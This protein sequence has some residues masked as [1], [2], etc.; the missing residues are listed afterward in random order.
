MN[1][2]VNWNPDE[3][4]IG[5]V[6]VAPAATA[7]FYTKL[8]QLTPAKKDWEHVRVIVDS[9]PKIPSRGRFF[10]LGE[11][12]P[13]PYIRQSIE[14]LIQV[15]ASIIAVPCNTAHVLYERYM[16]GFTI[17]IPNM[18]SLTVERVIQQSPIKPKKA[19]VFASKTTVEH[20][21]YNKAF[22]QHGII[23]NDT[24]NHQIEISA[25]I[26]KVKQGFSIALLRKEMSHLLNSY[27]EE[28]DV[29]I[30]GCTEL[31]LLI[32]NHYQG[33]AVIDS[34]MTLAESC[35]KMANNSAYLQKDINSQVQQY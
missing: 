24:S 11:T 5:V 14:Q 12:D 34:N 20:G 25:L 22:K 23:V 32:E 28:S 29:F 35:L 10:D 7:D 1:K 4:I 27:Q 21:L 15:G 19:T 16:T 18:I 30:L 2:E 13:V 17:S 33:I 8:I 9:N 31:S 6:G 26:E 3:K